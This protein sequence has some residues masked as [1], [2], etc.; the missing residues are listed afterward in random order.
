MLSYGYTILLYEI[1]TAIVNRGLNP[2]AGF[3]HQD[4]QGHPALASDLMEEWRAVLIDSLVMGMIQGHE[5]HKADFTRDEETKGIYLTK[6]GNRK[7]ITG[8]EKKVRTQS[9][10]FDKHNKVTFRRG[11]DLQVLSL[12]NAIEQNNID[13]YEPILIR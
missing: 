3:M 12:V 4:K 7:F 10:Y 2:Y 13:L 6:E 5:I 9:K 1:Y 11:I 8:F